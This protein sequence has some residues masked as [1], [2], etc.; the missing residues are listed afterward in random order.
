M[1]ILVI[2]CGSSS[3]K[4]KL[5]RVEG[6]KFRVLAA[7]LVERIGEEEASLHLRWPEG[8]IDLEPGIAS[9]HEALEG[10]E[11]E[12]VKQNILPDFSSLGLIAHRVVHGGERFHQPVVVDN[13]VMAVIRSLAPLAP[14]H[15]PYNLEGITAMREKAPE[16][17][18]VAV[19]DTAFHQT[20]PETSY[21]YALPYELYQNNHVRRYGFHGISHG[22]LLKTAAGFLKKEPEE[23]NLISLHLGNGA[24]AAAV[25]AGKCI[26]TSMGMT[27]MEGLVMGTRS[28]DLDP[29]ILLYLERECGLSIAELD[30]L[31]NSRS[32]LLG[33]CGENDMRE[34][35]TRLEQGDERAELA[36]AIFCYRLKKYIGAYAAVLGRLD[37]LVFSGGIGAKSA[38]IRER[39]CAWLDLLGI[40]LDPARNRSV[41]GEVAGIDDGSGGV[42]V[43]SIETDEELEIARQG[44]E[45]CS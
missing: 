34:I 8:R 26:D 37:A 36:C 17:A 4:C 27:P 31:L 45:L 35:L 32:G 23:V 9:H 5:F 19:F 6:G 21:L 14:L 28:G 13:E 7:G 24:S 39:V 16:V 40:R 11:R 25:R 42:R 18:Q 41:A 43:L 3:V 12:L 20:M 15:N 22:Y 2:N 29:G 38:V 30:R 33:V 44:L 10:L 1:K